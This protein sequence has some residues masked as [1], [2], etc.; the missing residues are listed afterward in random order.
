M[1]H[2]CLRGFESPGGNK[3]SKDS[4]MIII[5]LYPP[6]IIRVMIV[7]FCRKAKEMSSN[8]QGEAL[9]CNSNIIYVILIIMVIQML[10][11]STRGWWEECSFIGAYLY[12]RF[13]PRDSSHKRRIRNISPISIFYRLRIHYLTGNHSH[14]SQQPISRIERWTSINEG[15]FSLLCK[16]LQL[17]PCWKGRR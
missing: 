7:L 1:T 12:F 10:N 15:F 3:H 2:W 9:H 6:G 13:T 14:H 17:P 4:R 5:I 16:L 11:F 8:A